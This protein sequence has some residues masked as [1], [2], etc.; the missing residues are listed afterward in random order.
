MIGKVRARYYFDPGIS[1]ILE[2]T[3]QS[4]ICDFDGLPADRVM[5]VRGYATNDGVTIL[6]WREVPIV[7]PVIPAG[8]TLTGRWNSEIPPL[9]PRTPLDQR[10]LKF[11][12]HAQWY[13]VWLE[14]K[15]VQISPEVWVLDTDYT[16]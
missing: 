14:W 12:M 2:I 7:V 9:D 5:L 13:V 15:G 11:D 10:D 1:F 3:N 6:Q 4:L 16:P 8:V